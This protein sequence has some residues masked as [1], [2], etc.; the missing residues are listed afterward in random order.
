[1]IFSNWPFVLDLRTG[2][3][4][5]GGGEISILNA[6][7]A[8]ITNYLGLPSGVACAMTDAKALDAQ[9]GAEKA[10]SAL[11]TGLAGANL[12][13]ESAGMTASLLGASLESFVIDN[14]MISH[15]NRIIQGIDVNDETIGI[16]TIRKAAEGKDKHFLAAQQ[17][18]DAME[19]DYFYPELASR[20]DPRS[21]QENGKIDVWGKANIKVKKIL[22]EH[23]PNYIPKNADEEIR[24]QFRIYD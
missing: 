22:N 7:A 19:R 1:M 20:E 9:M 23:K 24:K 12:I 15:V 3:F 18:M 14:E 11:A 8:Q 21:W 2:A 13:Y 17:T 5:G 6:A 4:A 10:F 16:E